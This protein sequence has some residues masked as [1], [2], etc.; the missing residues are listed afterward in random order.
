M[1]IE[2]S[3]GVKMKKD[4]SCGRHEPDDEVC[5]VNRLRL[6]FDLHRVRTEENEQRQK[7]RDKCHS[8][9]TQLSKGRLTCY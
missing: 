8:F 6:F 4:I 2:G 5:V 7:K 9:Y 3:K 1:T